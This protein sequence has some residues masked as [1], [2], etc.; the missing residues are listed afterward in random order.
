VQKYHKQL[1]LLFFRNI[2]VVASNAFVSFR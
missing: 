1:E 2:N